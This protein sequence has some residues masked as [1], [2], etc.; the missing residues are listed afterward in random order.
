M[1]SAIRSR[2]MA[3]VT[4]IERA[5]PDGDNRL[6]VDADVA[7]QHAADIRAVLSADWLS[8]IHAGIAAKSAGAA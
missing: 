3:W 7:S 4:L 1:D 5:S 2:L 8:Q 6:L